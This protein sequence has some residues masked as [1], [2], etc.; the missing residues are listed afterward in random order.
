MLNKVGLLPAYNIQ[1]VPFAY[2]MYTSTDKAGW[3][4]SQEFKKAFCI[5]VN[6]EF[7]GVWYYIIWHSYVEE[8]DDCHLRDTVDSVGLFPKS[9]PFTASNTLV[10][11]FRHALSLDECRAKYKANLWN[12]S[13]TRPPDP[14]NTST[15][16]QEPMSP[17][18]PMNL[19]MFMKSLNYSYNPRRRRTDQYEK[20]Q[21]YY[22][23][24]YAPA[25]E[26][27][28]TDV[29]EVWFAVCSSQKCIRNPNV[30]STVFPSFFSHRAATV[31][32]QMAFLLHI[33]T[34]K[35]CVDVGGG[36]VDNKTRNSLAR[37]P[38]RWMIRE[39]FKAGTGIIFYVE[40][41]RELGLDP[42]T[43]SPAI[44]PRPPPICIS[45]GIIEEAPA[46]Q[47]W[48]MRLFSSFISML[49]THSPSDSTSGS[50]ESKN[51]PVVET[52]EEEEDLRDALSPMYDQLKIHPLWW[53]LEILPL[54]L[55]YQRENHSWVSYVGCVSV[56]LVI[57]WT[58][59][60]SCLASCNMGSPRHI[61]GQFERGV[62]MHRTVQTR[63]NARYAGDPSRRY[64]PAAYKALVKPIWV[65]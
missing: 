23:H 28:P 27:S 49:S 46:P 44:T 57:M 61:P 6:I 48:I 12:G 21:S 64:V 43:L 59:N 38:L 45:D 55:R 52:S 32:R 3:E 16:T 18:S 24:D 25:S 35:L 2:K 10:K 37:I 60:L 11:T 36:S 19:G 29:D 42:L 15:S 63:V 62:R 47:S 53:I 4:Q 34:N 40:G 7:V 22:E 9:L 26:R 54:K 65:D 13:Y 20:T 58:T 1:Q 50:T 39:C 30:T 8:V 56:D 33:D 41:L 31:V 5:N 51:T 14:A 17:M